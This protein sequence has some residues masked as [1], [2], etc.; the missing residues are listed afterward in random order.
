MHG[1]RIRRSGAARQHNHGPCIHALCRNANIRGSRLLL[2][3]QPTAARPQIKIGSSLNR[4]PLGNDACSRF[5]NIC[6]IPACRQQHRA[7]N[8]CSVKQKRSRIPHC[9][10]SAFVNSGSGDAGSEAR[11]IGVV[12]IICG[13][14]LLCN[15]HRSTFSVLLPL[16]CDKFDFSISQVGL[17]QSTMLLAYLIGQLPSGDLADKLGG[18]R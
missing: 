13:G 4:G 2:W 12:A 9:R 16:L 6:P 8:D 7:F 15:L 18:E 14:M 3:Q 10:A 5:L 1:S 17:M 11:P